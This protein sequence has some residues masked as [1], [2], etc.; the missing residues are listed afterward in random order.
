MTASSKSGR[1]GSAPAGRSREGAHTRQV[2]PHRHDSPAGCV[3]DRTTPSAPGTPATIS[4]GEPSGDGATLLEQQ[5]RRGPM[6]LVDVR[7]CGDD[8]GSLCRRTRDEPPQLG[9]AHRIDAGG[10]L[11]EHQ[12]RRAVQQRHA[13]RELA[14]HAPGQL[15]AEPRSRVPRARFD[16]AT[17][18]IAG[19]ARRRATRTRLRRMRGSRRR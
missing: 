3:A 18:W 17:A 15:P 9:T 2:A 7:G 13:D 19:S 1:R 5:D 4:D 6:R 16:P 10:R 14:L 8:G 12:H 11:V